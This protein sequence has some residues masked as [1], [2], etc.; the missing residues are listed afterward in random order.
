MYRNDGCVFTRGVGNVAGVKECPGKDSK[1]IV[2]F[3]TMQV[4]KFIPLFSWL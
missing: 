3:N 2:D 1:L 4:K